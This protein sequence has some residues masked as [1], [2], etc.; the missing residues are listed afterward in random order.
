GKSG[1]KRAII[2]TARK[3]AVLLHHLWVSG[4]VYEPLHNGGRMAMPAAAVSTPL[5][6]LYSDSS[7]SSRPLAKT[8]VQMFLSGSTFTAAIC[9]EFHS[10]CKPDPSEPAF[11]AWLVSGG[12]SES[13]PIQERRPV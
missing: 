7:C 3:L 6:D 10:A 5:A 8:T 2:A 4:E 13:R 11:C 9:R 1:K 12:L